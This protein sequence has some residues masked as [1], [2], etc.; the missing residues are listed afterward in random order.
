MAKEQ[1]PGHPDRVVLKGFH[2][3]SHQ[4]LNAFLKFAANLGLKYD[5]GIPLPT[6]DP[7][8]NEPQPPLIVRKNEPDADITEYELTKDDFRWTVGRYGYARRTASGLYNAVLN[9]EASKIQS[10]ELTDEQSTRYLL[11]GDVARLFVEDTAGHRPIDDV[12]RI[13]PRSEEML[14]LVVADKQAQIEEF[15]L[16]SP[17]VQAA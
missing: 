13:G 11:F 12:D 9:S 15:Q 4:E 5:L 14:K 2:N 6:V 1:Y 17:D 8:F 7:E 10:S 16:Q 3:F